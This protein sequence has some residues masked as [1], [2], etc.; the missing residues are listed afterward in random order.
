VR[1]KSA[2]STLRFA[3]NHLAKLNIWFKWTRVDSVNFCWEIH[4]QSSSACLKKLKYDNN[5]LKGDFFAVL[6]ELRRLWKNGGISPSY[7][8]LKKNDKWK[9]ANNE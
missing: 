9:G 4:G 1:Q 6:K 7:V 5:T 8:A 2:N 3:I